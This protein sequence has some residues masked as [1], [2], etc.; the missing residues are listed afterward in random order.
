MIF[1]SVN[2]KYM[3]NV[4][5]QR[6]TNVALLVQSALYKAMLENDATGMQNTLNVIN[7]MTGVEDVTV[8]NRQDKPSYTSYEENDADHGNPNCKQCHNDVA[9]LFSDEH[10]AFRIID[11]N[12]SCDM[13]TGYE[14]ERQLFVR[15][16]I[17]NE[18]SC[19][20]AAC[21]AHPR[22]H[23]ILGSLIIKLPLD[24]LDSA[25]DEIT[26][27]F[28]LAATAMTIGLLIILVYFTHKRIKEPLNSLMSVSKAVK[29]GDRS[30]R[31]E[32][33]PNQL[34]DM[35]MLSMT[36]N[37]MLDNLESANT[38]LENWSQQLEYKVRK[39]TEE[40]GQV[41]NELINVERTAS[42]GKLS[43]SVAHEI[44]NPLS[45]ILIYTK[46][47]RK[48]IEKSDI[49]PDKKKN[50][51]KHLM[52]TENESKRCG[53]IVKGLLDFSRKDQD[54]FKVKHLH[55]ILSETYDLMAHS[56]KIAK[57]LFLSDFSAEKDSVYCNPNQLKQACITVLVNASEA[58]NEK[59]EIVL[60]TYNPDDEHIVVRIDDNGSG[61]PESVLPHVFEPFF[62]TKQGEK[63][64]GLGLAIT[65]GII[66]N[67]DGKINLE[68]ELNKGTSVIITL[69]IK[70]KTKQDK[71]D[72]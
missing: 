63:G 37:Q 20:N 21:H 18:P 25:Q 45:G 43:L 50:M 24:N 32:I 57:I 12:S 49:D 59:G 19:Y 15:S 26:R 36:F 67:H 27:D 35:K 39:K 23:K 8:Y 4:I 22:E 64:I 11:V 55:D 34:H 68:S 60:R 65:H 47:V 72:R 9:T 30:R 2:E 42:L 28:F 53:N 70:H 44:N 66:K 17:L 58:I 31:V 16:A 56:M 48:Q 54:T 13:N 40:L 46:L 29:K 62:T 5:K 51:V 6:G 61:I 41:Q 52:M 69:P 38:E 7:K 10:E 3:Q 71:H 1:R 33:S 14:T